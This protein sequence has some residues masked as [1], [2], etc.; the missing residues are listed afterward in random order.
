[1]TLNCAPTSYPDGVELTEDAKD[2][3]IAIAFGE[4]TQG[5][6]VTFNVKNGEGKFGIVEKTIS[7]GLSLKIKRNTIKSLTELVL[8]PTD[9]NIETYSLITDPAS[10]TPGTY[11]LAAKSGDTYHIWTGS[12]SSKDLAT[13]A[14]T[15]NSSTKVLTGTGAGDVVLT[16]TG[17][18]NQ[19]YVIVG[20]KYLTS[21]KAENR[22]LRLDDPETSNPYWTF[23][24]DSRGGMTMQSSANTVYLLSAKTS[25]AVLRS[26]TSSTQGNFGVY[27]FKK[28]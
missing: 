25:S 6:K 28:D 27:L 16:S 1:M 21:A 14:Y 8:N 24:T 20:G 17:T 22:N 26:Y 12:M 2:F 23:G 18:E 19:F 11:Y 7:N 15:Y 10:I 13:V 3:Y 5:L 4:Y 9:N